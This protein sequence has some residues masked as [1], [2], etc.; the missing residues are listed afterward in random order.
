[1]TMVPRFFSI[2]MI[3]RR[4]LIPGFGFFPAVISNGAKR[5]ARAPRAR[6][7]RKLVI[8]VTICVR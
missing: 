2:G 4:S 7:K 8:V 5:R 1:M 3:F 6:W